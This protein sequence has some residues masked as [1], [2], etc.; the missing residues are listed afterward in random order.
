MNMLAGMSE[1]LKNFAQR[2]NVAINDPNLVRLYR[3]EQD[4]IRDEKSRMGFATKEARQE[5]VQ[6]GHKIGLLEA[7]R[8]DALGMKSI[9]IAPEAISKITGLSINEIMSL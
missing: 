4:A 6:E 2:Y 9:G 7:H 5:G 3:L 1:G 8:A